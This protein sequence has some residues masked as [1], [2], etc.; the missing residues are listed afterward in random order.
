[1]NSKKRKAEEKDNADIIESTKENETADINASNCGSG[2]SGNSTDH[3][4]SDNGGASEQPGTSDEGE[5]DPKETNDDQSVDQAENKHTRLDNSEAGGELLFC[6]GTNWDL[7]GR[8]ELPKYAKDAVGKNLWGPH[9]LKSLQGIKVTAVFAGSCAVHSVIL[10][11]GGQAFTWGRN[12]KGQLGHC[13]NIRRDIPT[14]V[15]TLKEHVIVSASCGRGHTLFV[16]ERGICYA[17]G[18]NKCGQ[19]GIGS[20]NTAINIPTK[21]SFKGRSISKVACGAEFSMIVDVKGGL[22]SFGSPEYGQLGHNSDGRYFVTSNKLSYKCELAPRRIVAFIEKNREGHVSL[23]D[24]VAITDVACG[25]NHSVAI[26]TQK[27]CF[28]WGFGGYGRLGTNEPK[29][30]YVPRLITAL[31][32]PKNAGSVKKIFAGGTYSLAINEYDVLYFFG[33]NRRTGEANMY[34]KPV[35]DLIGWRVRD[36]GCANN[37][38]VCLA[39]DSV[40]S[41][42]PSPTYGELGYGESRSRSSTTPQEVKPLEGV[43]IHSVDCGYGHTLLIAK[44]DTEEDRKKLNQFPEFTP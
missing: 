35:Q 26:D 17:T 29:D 5:K 3:E 4:K 10:I 30:E 14:R 32:G 16:S 1:M 19:C 7:I 25:I 2:E 44:N 36:V 23:V 42:G 38:I 13:D 40:I 24:D 18:D 33:Q 12:D 28:S 43:Y 39:D 21:I 20:Q 27:R 8:K 6:G 41:W 15:E 9:R 11:E 31:N 22:Y 37:S 34:P